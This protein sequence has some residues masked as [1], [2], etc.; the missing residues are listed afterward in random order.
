MPGETPGLPV[1]TECV[2]GIPLYLIPKVISDQIKKKREAV[3]TISVERR[4]NH[5]YTVSVQSRDD[6]KNPATPPEH[7]VN[8][9][10]EHHG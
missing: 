5:R 3:F 7:V 8:E 6:Q 10:G 9:S 2:E 1:E 4:F